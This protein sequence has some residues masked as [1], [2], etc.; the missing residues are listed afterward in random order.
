[1]NGVDILS[2]SQVNVINQSMVVTR[3][4]GCRYDR[5]S[6]S[7]ARAFLQGE[8]KRRE[9]RHHRVIDY[10]FSCSVA[11]SYLLPTP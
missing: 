5:D 4:A 9:G 10:R 2:G 8:K 6:G 3:V 1:M 11:T 7:L